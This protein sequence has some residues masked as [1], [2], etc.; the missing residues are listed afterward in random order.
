MAP[1]TD[2]AR[3]LQTLLRC[4]SVTPLD[5]GAVAALDAVLTPHGFQC[6]TLRFSEQGTADVTNLF[7]RFGGSDPHF[8]FAGHS[9]V[10][11]PG[12]ETRWRHPPFAGTIADGHVH[13][14]GAC[15]MKGSL[16]AFAAAA[17]DFIAASGKVFTGSISLLITGDEEGPAINGTAKVLQWLKERHGLPAHCLVGEP[18]SHSAVGDQ[19][20]IGRR[21]S[22]TVHLTVDG[23]QGHAAYPHLADNPVPKLA[24]LIDRLSGIRLDE[25]TANFEP[26]TL[27]V[28][29]FDVGNPASNVIPGHAAA[30]LNIRY[31]DAHSAASLKQLIE[32]EIA[33]VEQQLGGRFAARYNEGADV[34][35]T[36]PGAFVDL[37]AGAVKRVT[38]LIS[39][40]S[41]SGGTSDARFI[42]DFCPVLELGPINATIHQTDERI[43][44]S[45]LNRL[46]DIYRAILEDYFAAKD[47][48]SQ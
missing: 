34:F 5:A 17:I 22:I 39:T 35:V 41:T 40:P 27:A 16:A 21:G 4:R 10:V 30:T 3:I 15:D 37:V 45:D 48:R 43:A 20:K 2:P 24:R 36:K 18:T 23:Q 46:R 25:G 32:R 9:D 7:A 26:S 29:T 1:L 28:S 11:P 8:C 13:G 6:E 42:K 31:N 38:G 12:D 47:L 14:R 19:M 44:V 33:I